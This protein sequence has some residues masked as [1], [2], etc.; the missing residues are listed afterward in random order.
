MV[1]RLSALTRPPVNALYR[2]DAA[3]SQCAVPCRR[4]LQSMRCTALARRCGCGS[5]Y[6]REWSAG[7]AFVPAG[8]SPGTGDCARGGTDGAMRNCCPRARLALRFW[9]GVVLARGWLCVPVAALFLGSR[10]AVRFWRGVALA[11]G[12]PCGSGAALFLGSRPALRFCRGAFPWRAPGIAFLSRRFSSVHACCLSCDKQDGLR[13][14][15]FLF[16]RVEIAI[17]AFSR[18]QC[19]YLPLL[20]HFGFGRFFMAIPTGDEETRRTRGR[21][22]G[23]AARRLCV[24]A[25]SYWPCNAFRGESVGGCAPPN[26]RQRVFDSL[27]S[28]HA[29]AGLGWCGFAA[30][31][32]GHYRRPDRL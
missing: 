4:G 15:P 27:D 23:L 8:F 17:R 11:R 26:L 10:S 21:G 2:A 30:P 18:C 3:S 13:Y 7:A 14:A 16:R 32:P 28:L 22:T 1:R 19:G 29:A 6:V 9:R 24:F 25:Q 20:V 12:W 5:L 31:S